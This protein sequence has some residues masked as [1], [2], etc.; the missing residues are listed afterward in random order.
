MRSAIRLSKPFACLAR[1]TLSAALVLGALAVPAV[2]ASTRVPGSGAPTVDTAAFRGLGRLAFIWD[3][4]PYVLD[5]AKGSLRALG[6]SG[7]V[8]APAWSVDGH[9]LAYID[10]GSGADPRHVLWVVGPDGSHARRFR[11][12]PGPAEG[13]A[14]SPVADQLAVRVGGRAKTAGALWLVTP[15]GSPRKTALPDA[16]PFWSPDGKLFAYVT[17]L[18]SNIPAA[19]SD[20]LNTVPVAGG[21]PAR[22]LSAFESG[23]EPAGWWPSGKGL[24]YWLDPGHSSSLAADGLN[25]FALALGGRQP[26]LLI[27]MLAYADWLARAPLD[28]DLLLVAGAGRMAWQ[29]KS[30]AVCDVARAACRSLPQA[31]GTVS[32]DPAWAPRGNQIAYV[33]ARAL[34]VG[35]FGSD[36]ALREWVRSRTLVIAR[37]DGTGAHVFSAAG[38]GVYQPQW[39]A[40]GRHL[41]YWRDDA[42][43]LLDRLGGTPV[44]LVSAFPNSPDPRG[45]FGYVSWSGLTAWYR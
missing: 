3:G 26:H 41:L 9:W 13:L 17:T 24:L 2:R 39:A 20:V 6:Q 42:L 44:R 27:T 7:V 18:P 10:A 1:G 4:R 8:S 12:L 36:K 16:R 37:P 30:L 38:A 19:R 43:W 35:G 28:Q 45:F 21:A 23:I 22:Q 5:G 25:L 33:R 31:G 34:T 14:W 15:T 29:Q 40:D 11:M 32:L